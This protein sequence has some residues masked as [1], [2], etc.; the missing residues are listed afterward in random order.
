MRTVAKRAS[1]VLLGLGLLSL[2]GCYTQLATTE[3]E[4][5]ETYVE[6]D[7]LSE[8]GNVTINNNYYLDDDYRR[9]RF[10]LSFNYYYPTYHSSWLS[11]YFYS[12]YDDPYWGWGRPGW[13][14]PSYTVVTPWPWWPPYYDPWWPYGYHPYY[15]PVVYY[16]IHHPHHDGWGGGVASP[17]SRPRPT[18]PTRDPNDPGGRPR[19]LPTDPGT[20]PIT[21]GGGDRPRPPVAEVPPGGAINRP[22][23]TEQVTHDVPETAPVTR[24]RPSEPVKTVVPEERPREEKPWWV[25]DKEEK[26]E[27]EPSARPA[28]PST[29]APERRQRVTDERPASPSPAKQPSAR[30]AERRRET[31]SEP[32][33]P[34]SKPSRPRE[35]RRTYSP[36]APQS[37]PPASAPRSGGGSSS[38]SSSGSGGGRKRGE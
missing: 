7:T 25:R 9:S 5:E 16:P 10:R 23:P 22:R 36:P 29:P 6:S 30:P 20:G 34:P 32:S 35:E 1:S 33:A 26:R 28:S 24:P 8:D 13:W 19:P 21:T 3:Y 11:G 2:T 17:P 14:Y 38:G 12:Y 4:S 31:T 27:R 37:A 18:G 15:P